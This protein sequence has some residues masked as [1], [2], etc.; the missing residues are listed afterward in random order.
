[1]IRYDLRMESGWKRREI[2]ILKMK[3][4]DEMPWFV[5]PGKR[6]EILQ[7]NTTTL[8]NIYF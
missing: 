7:P 5:K 2:A 3:K 1:V 6:T 8:E 4:E